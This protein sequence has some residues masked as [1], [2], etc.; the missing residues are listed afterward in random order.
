MPTDDTAQ[1]SEREQTDESLRVEREKV[2][3]ALG[4]ELAAI[5]ETADAI[6][7]PG[8]R[9]RRQPSDGDDVRD[10]PEVLL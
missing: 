5:D 3:Q 10:G 9:A 6:I 7:K 1:S 4:E 8:S 2:D